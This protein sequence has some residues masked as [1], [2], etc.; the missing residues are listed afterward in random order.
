MSSYK[1]SI[2]IIFLSALVCPKFK[3]A[4]LGGGCEPPILGKGGRRGSGIVPFERALVSFYRLSI[5]TF[6]LPLR[7]SEILP[8]LFSST[9][10]F[11][12]PTS[13]FPKKFFHVPLGVGGSP[14]GYKERRCWANCCAISFQDFQPMWSQITNVTDRQTDRQTDGRHAIPRPRKCTKV[15]CAV[16]TLQNDVTF[17]YDRSLVNQGCNCWGRGRSLTPERNGWLGPTKSQK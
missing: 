6:P 10:L 1:P 16:K 2:H 13:S 15:H 12:Y 5:V 17:N 11:P 8:L 9:P 7:V 3:I 14:F 4:V